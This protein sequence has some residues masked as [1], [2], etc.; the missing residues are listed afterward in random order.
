MICADAGLAF[1]TSLHSLGG[2][3][4]ATISVLT[5]EQLEETERDLDEWAR[6]GAWEYRGE[7]LLRDVFFLDDPDA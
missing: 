6:G 5:L 2:S 4:D 3:S 1:S 7:R